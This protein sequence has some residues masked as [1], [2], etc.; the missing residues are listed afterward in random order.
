ME[1]QVPRRQQGCN[2]HRQTWC[3]AAGIGSRDYSSGDGANGL[4]LSSGRS[5]AVTENIAAPLKKRKWE[6]FEAL[7]SPVVPDVYT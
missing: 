6:I 5:L 3:A 7:G 1:T 2:S 4:H